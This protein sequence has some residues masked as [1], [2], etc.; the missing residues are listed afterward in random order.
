MCSACLAAHYSDVIMSAMVSQNTSLTIFYSTVYSVVDQ[1]KHQ[2][3]AS[4]AFVRGIH[5]WPVNSP[6]KGPVTRK[7]F[8]FDDVIM[9]D[10]VSAGDIFSHYTPLILPYNSQ[11][12]LYVFA[13]VFGRRELYITLKNRRLCEKSTRHNEEPMN[14]MRH[15]REK[16]LSERRLKKHRYKCIWHPLTQVTKMHAYFYPS[17][18]SPQYCVAAIPKI[19][20]M[21]LQPVITDDFV[22]I[23][24]VVIDTIMI[25]TF[26]VA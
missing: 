22:I 17:H 13:D 21:L 9:N 6:H 19:I 10:W 23:I 8:T 18:W 20:L 2:S 16:A 12:N 25:I 11:V 24:V 26:I 14:T 15:D 3:S 4:L 5:L 7:M 1:R